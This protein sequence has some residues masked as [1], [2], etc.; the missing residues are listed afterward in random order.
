MRIVISLSI[1]L[2]ALSWAPHVTANC[3]DANGNLVEECV[4]DLSCDICGFYGNSVSNP[5]DCFTC[6]NGVPVEVIYDDGSGTCGAPC[7]ALEN[8]LPVEGCACDSTCSTCRFYDGVFAGRIDDC[9]T[10]PEG[11][12]FNLLYDDGTGT[13][14]TPVD[15]TQDAE[16]CFMVF[17]IAG[18][19]LLELGNKM[20]V[21]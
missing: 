21:C 11:V 1:A 20:R 19:Y 10:C 4:C 3:L 14:G 15:P 12:P 2:L 17:Q 13:C 7:L 16:I 8:D 9:L 6:A 18:T 5:D